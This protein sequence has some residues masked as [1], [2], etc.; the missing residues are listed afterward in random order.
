MCY[1]TQIALLEKGS[2]NEFA[3]IVHIVSRSEHKMQYV[4]V[5]KDKIFKTLESSTIPKVKI[6]L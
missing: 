3:S 6:K 4:N 5:S 2:V 1:V